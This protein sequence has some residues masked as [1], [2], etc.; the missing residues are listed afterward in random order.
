[1]PWIFFLSHCGACASV[2]DSVRIRA[3]TTLDQDCV[4]KA[5]VQVC[6]ACMIVSLLTTCLHLNKLYLLSVKVLKVFK[7]LKSDEIL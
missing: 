6:A 5:T 3:D 1:M 7:S 4:L 2:N